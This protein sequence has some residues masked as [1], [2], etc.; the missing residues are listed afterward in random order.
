M[1][2]C[3]TGELTGKIFAWACQAIAPLYNDAAVLMP[4]KC[5]LAC[6]YERIHLT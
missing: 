2:Q 6:I 5:Y 1:A 3:G 4:H